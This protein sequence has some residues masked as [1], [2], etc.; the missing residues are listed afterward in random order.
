MK[1]I[2]GLTLASALLLVGCYTGPSASHYLA[3]VEEIVVPAGWHVAATVVRGPDQAVPCNPGVS[4]ECPAVRRY[5]LIDADIAGAYAEAM[6]LVVGAGFTIGD[7]STQGCTTGSSNGP[8]CG[9]FAD[10]GSDLLHVRVYAS[11]GEAG[12][13]EADP[14]GVTVVLRASGSD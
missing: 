6:D 5:F 2:V 8:P 3:I 7:E 1:G 14:G 4:T 9:F 12:L 13:D 10:R 11:P